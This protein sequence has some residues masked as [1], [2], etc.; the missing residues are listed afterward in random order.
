MLYLLGRNKELFT[1]DINQHEKTIQKS[2]EKMLDL[3]KSR[4]FFCK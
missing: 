1:Q 4:S 2:F 3:T